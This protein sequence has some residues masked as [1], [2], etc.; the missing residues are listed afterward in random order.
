LRVFRANH[1]ARAHVVMLNAHVVILNEHLFD[2]GRRDVS[3]LRM[4]VSSARPP[5]NG[6]P[7]VAGL[8]A[9][10]RTLSATPRAARTSVTPRR[11]GFSA[12]ITRQASA[13]SVRR[14]RRP[15]PFQ[16]LTVQTQFN[17]LMAQAFQLSAFIGIEHRASIEL[18]R[19]D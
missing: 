19:A 9:I 12:S 14:R 11:A 8:A 10:C 7:A 3:P 13:G 1:R 5:M 4:I 18:R 2:L 6:Y 17:I 15:R 16:K